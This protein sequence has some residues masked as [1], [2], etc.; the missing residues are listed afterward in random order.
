MTDAVLDKSSSRELVRSLSIIYDQYTRKITSASPHLENL[1]VI[2][3][4][5][6]TTI[7]RF[8]FQ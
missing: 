6:L 2:L 8:G 7:F 1:K 3:I 5:I 4:M